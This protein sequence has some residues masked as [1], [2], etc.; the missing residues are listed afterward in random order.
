MLEVASPPQ[1]GLSGPQK[2]AV[3][4][5]QMGKERSATVLRSL[6]ES[7]VE[8]LMGEIARLQGLNV[9]V[10][11]EV[12]EE[13]H[14]LAVARRYVTQG[15]MGFAQEVLE[16]SMGAGKAREILDRLQAGM[17]DVPFEFL[18]RADPRQ[19][20][21]YLQDE[22]PQTIA[23]V[24]A[25][26]HADHAAMV[27]SGLSEELQADVAHRVATMEQTSPE[28]IARV[29]SVLERKLSSLLQAG[30]FAAAGGVKP[31][32]DIL[33]RSDRTTERLILE[34]LEGRDAELAEAVR[35]LMF[36]FED[37]T[38]LDDRSVQLLLREVDGKE[39]AIALKGVR[40]D[41]RD[42][43]TKNMSERA[44]TILLEEI[45]MLGPVRLK[46]VEESQANIVRAVRS[47]EEAGQIIL[48]RGGDEF[49]D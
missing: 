29:E 35:S 34:G 19:V 28:I 13:F 30:D 48:S 21:T 5:L 39:L 47:L 45:S 1:H 25:H 22:H 15:G 24:I 43:I 9:E 20:L 8:E 11:D 44:A 41:V 36:V 49:I 10:A 33:N 17:V 42:K 27:L 7:E 4:L 12:L 2:A 31:L 37:I 14:E 3:V 38:S 32:V 18:R 23:L 40:D 6:K 46:T 26:M 16:A